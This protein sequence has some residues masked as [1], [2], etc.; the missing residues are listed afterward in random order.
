MTL[1]TER[2]GIEDALWSALEAVG[3][4]LSVGA[5]GD[6]A[7]LI[8][9]REYLV[10]YETLA[11]HAYEYAVDIEAGLVSELEVVGTVLGADPK[12]GELFTR[13]AR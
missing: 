6:I 7:I 10:A 8:R 1:P 3:D 9:V 13:C 4:A 2:S 11:T 5:I 12:Y